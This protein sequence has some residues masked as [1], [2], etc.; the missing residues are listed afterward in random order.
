MSI[1]ER[2]LIS[3]NGAS[4]YVRVNSDQTDANVQLLCIHLLF[5]P[6][7]C[8]PDVR[9]VQFEELQYLKTDPLFVV[10]SADRFSID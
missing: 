6:I 5:V 2:S 1:V 10:V 7:I 8:I 9:N 4:R 3:A